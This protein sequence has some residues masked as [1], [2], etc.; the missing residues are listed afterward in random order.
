[1]LAKNV[2][3]LADCCIALITLVAL[4]V[5][6]EAA[7][8]ATE[9]TESAVQRLG[10]ILFFDPNLSADGKVSC[11]TCHQPSHEFAENRAV[12]AGA[13]GRV[14]TRNAPSL[15]GRRTNDP[16]FWDG[17]RPTLESQVMDPIF[18]PFEHGLASMD[19][20]LK[21]LGADT[22]YE[23]LF[24]AAFEQSTSKVSAANVA[25]ALTDFVASIPSAPTRVERFLAGDRKA[26]TDSEKQGMEIFAKRAQCAQCHL[27][28]QRSA[29]FSDGKFHSVGIGLAQDTPIAPL[30][31]R[32]LEKVNAVGLDAAIFSDPEV[33][34]L[35]RFLV[36]K[37]PRDISKFRTP[38]LRRVSATAPYMHDGSIGTLEE[39]LDRELYY[40]SLAS[41]IP[42][43]LT[44]D[45]RANL[46]AFLSA[47]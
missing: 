5:M 6:A 14:G 26:L 45:E 37:D 36:T 40:R 42:I 29:G 9:R 27:I 34:Q 12:S 10:R 47:L 13:F 4:A 8:F 1:V 32:A 25:R 2:R 24:A 30:V 46:L 15:L 19:E 21:K 28:D 41:G 20:L 17:R 11:A 31:L 16:L 7:V 18:N 22:A 3:R 44:P 43:A 39:A 33:S 35:G 38:A 23:P